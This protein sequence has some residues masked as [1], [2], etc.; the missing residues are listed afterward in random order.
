MEGAFWED[1]DAHSGDA[2]EVR[3]GMARAR[4]AAAQAKITRNR[5]A[6]KRIEYIQ[7]RARRSVRPDL[8]DH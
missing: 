4:G 5:T 7:D 3:D 1:D 6:E 8:P 2:R